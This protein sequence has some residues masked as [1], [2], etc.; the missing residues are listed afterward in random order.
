LALTGCLAVGAAACASSANRPPTEQVSVTPTTV[1]VETNSAA[2]TIRMN[3]MNEDRADS[4]VIKA[5]ID[6]AWGQLPAVYAEL[7]LPVSVYVDKSRQIATRA[8]RFRG[9]VG[10]TR[11]A[12]FV[13]CGSDISGEDKANIYEITLDVATTLAPS[14]SGQTNVMTMVTASGRPMATSGDAVRCTSNGTLE[15]RIATALTVRT[16]AAK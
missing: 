10:K 12:Q 3:L 5:D 1:R 8:A 6:R 7:E 14:E 2:G 13:S 9:K 11:L 15:R 4:R 16:A